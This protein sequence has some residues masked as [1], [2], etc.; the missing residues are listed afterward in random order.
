MQF[1]KL[2]RAHFADR[3]QCKQIVLNLSKFKAEVQTVLEESDD[4]RGNV[5]KKLERKVDT[6]IP[7]DF[8]SEMKVFK[9][10]PTRKFKVD[11]GFSI[12][13]AQASLWLESPEL[14]E[15]VD[16]MA[17]DAIDKELKIFKKIVVIEQ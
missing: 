7:M 16:K 8:E 14:A 10:M 6:D 17:N 5:T 3:E 15:I 1:L 2:R 13:D 11:I 12:N 9:G 4:S